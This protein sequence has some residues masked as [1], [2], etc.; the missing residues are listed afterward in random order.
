MYTTV[1]DLASQINTWTLKTLQS[2]K[3]KPLAQHFILE[4]PL[5]QNCTAPKMIRKYR[6]NT[7]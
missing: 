4:F 1:S 5:P 2:V 6:K 7:L 3:D